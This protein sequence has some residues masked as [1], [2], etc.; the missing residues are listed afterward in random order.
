MHNIRSTLVGS[1]WLE[2]SI[3]IE[4]LISGLKHLHYSTKNYTFQYNKQTFH[5]NQHRKTNHINQLSNG[6]SEFDNDDICDVAH[7]PGPF[8][9]S[10]K[11]I[12]E[13]KVFS[14]CVSPLVSCH[15]CRQTDRQT[16]QILKC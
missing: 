15:S 6:E 14:M 7:W 8:V 10:L 12:F 3:A 4:L 2:G 5:Q 16:R 13:K 11:E 9:I 1:R